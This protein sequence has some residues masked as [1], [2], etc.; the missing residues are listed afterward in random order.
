LRHCLV[1]AAGP[2]IGAAEVAQESH[3]DRIACDRILA[4]GDRLLEATE[5]VEQGGAACEHLQIGRIQRQRPP[6][7]PRRALQVAQVVRDP[8][9]LR[10]RRRI[11]RV[12]RQRL[13][14]GFPRLR[15]RLLRRKGSDGSPVD[16]IPA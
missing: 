5:T 14:D 7:V 3:I 1:V 8:A 11:P 13:L 2:S 9:E 10:V 4:Y 12:D 6:I 16:E 15:V